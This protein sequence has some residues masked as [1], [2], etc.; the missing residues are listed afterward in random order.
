MMREQAINYFALKLSRKVNFR[1][2]I[3]QRPQ[4]SIMSLRGERRKLTGSNMSL[5]ICPTSQDGIHYNATTTQNVVSRSPSHTAWA[6]VSN[7]VLKRKKA[8]FALHY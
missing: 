1:T 4:V 2:P 8:F 6:S 7:S 5:M 3:L